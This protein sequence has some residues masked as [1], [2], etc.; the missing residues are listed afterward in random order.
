MLNDWPNDC[1]GC[2][3]KC[4][5]NPIGTN[6]QTT[7]KDFREYITILDDKDGKKKL[8]C[9]YLDR[10]SSKCIIYDHRP[11]ICKDFKFSNLKTEHCWIIRNLEQFIET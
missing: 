2:G 9:K 11:Q 1:T 3:G 7:R 4:C 6:H 5:Y 8:V 10:T